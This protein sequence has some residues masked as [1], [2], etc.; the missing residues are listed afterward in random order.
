VPVAPIFQSGKGAYR[1]AAILLRTRRRRRCQPFSQLSV[2]Q[3]RASSRAVHDRPMTITCTIHDGTRRTPVLTASAWIPA[4]CLR[5]AGITVLQGTPRPASTT[6]YSPNTTRRC[7]S[8]AIRSVNHGTRCEQPSRRAK[9]PNQC[10]PIRKCLSMPRI[11]RKL[12]SW[13]SEMA[14]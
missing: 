14:G 11:P 8:L 3:M 9:D 6:Q 12:G 7:A 1:R 5:A 2:S 10:R 13:C 4:R